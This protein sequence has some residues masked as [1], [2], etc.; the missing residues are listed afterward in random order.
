MHCV[1]RM[2]LCIIINSSLKHSP[3]SEYR[4]HGS[5]QLYL[6]EFVKKAENMIMNIIIKTINK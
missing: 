2:S 4:S 5:S 1:R 3:V 6:F